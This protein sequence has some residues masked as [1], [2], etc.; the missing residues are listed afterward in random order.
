MVPRVERGHNRENHIHLSLYWKKSSPEP[1]GQLQSNLV[2]TYLTWWEFKFI[3][4]KVLV[5]FK[6]LYS[7]KCKNRL[8][9]FKLFL[10]MNHSTIKAQIYMSAS[11]YSA[12]SNLFNLWSLGIIG[13]HN[14]VK[15]FYICFN[16][17]NLFKN[18]QSQKKVQI[19]WQG[20]LMT[21]K[22]SNVA[23]VHRW[24]T[25][26]SDVVPGPVVGLSVCLQKL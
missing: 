18:P 7:Q 14:R 1:A 2:Q 19:Y 24:K 23:C 6:G 26:V 5:L 4:M 21:M 3:Q 16:G 17:K 10:L 15:H 22:N 9:S 20:D 8:G 11:R 13:G 25:Q 12:E